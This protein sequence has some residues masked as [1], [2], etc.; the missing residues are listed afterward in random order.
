MGE[1][2]TQLPT[3]RDF[4]GTP[5]ILSGHAVIHL[6]PRKVLPAACNYRGQHGVAPIGSNF[7]ILNE[8]KSAKQHRIPR[9]MPLADFT[10]LCDFQKSGRENGNFDGRNAFRINPQLEHADMAKH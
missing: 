6:V 7:W 8:Q 4:L 2:V 9:E 5:Q 10:K 3:D 1:V